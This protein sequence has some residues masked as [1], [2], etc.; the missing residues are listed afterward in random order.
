MIRRPFEPS[1]KEHAQRGQEFSSELLIV[2]FRDDVVSAPPRARLFSKR[3]MIANAVLPASLTS[4]LEALIQEESLRS[5][6]PL[7]SPDS[8]SKK[9]ATAPAQNYVS[10]IA[11]SILQAD[12]DD[13]AGINV[14]RFDP[15]ADLKKLETKVSN[16]PG[17]D[18]C[19]RVPKR[20]LA[21]RRVARPVSDPMVNRQ[22]ALR[23]IRWFDVSALPDASKVKVA[24]L[25][26]GIDTEHPDLPQPSLYDH[27]GSSVKDLIGHGTHVAGVISAKTNNDMG[28]AGM[29]SCDLHIWKLFRDEP[30]E[31]DEFCVDDQLYFRALNEA[32]KAGVHVM[33]LS[34]GGPYATQ[35]ETILFRRLIDAGVT[36]VAAMGNGYQEGN[37]IEY[38]GAH[39]GVLAIAAL[40]EAN[41]RAR[42]SSTGPHVALS[43]PGVNILSTVPLKPSK[44]CKRDEVEYAAWDGT[45]MATPH[46]A[47]AAALL[48]AKYPSM[49]PVEVVKKLKAGVNKLKDK[50]QYVG[51]GLLNVEKLLS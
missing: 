48:R 15:S 21:A 23:A 5:V 28:I 41:R 38:P 17:V 4:P 43:A 30:D 16:M 25:D 39:E 47:A 1:E 32:L 3:L 12:D 45:S 6:T 13:L 42:F 29:A 50:P 8:T 18:Y 35:T 44:A 46:V 37:Y 51:S 40:D 11:S 36:V 9:T 31:D 2:K 10:R 24:I 14:L 34:L 27:R 26:S 20:R 7:F 49:S 22:W 19:H 33:N